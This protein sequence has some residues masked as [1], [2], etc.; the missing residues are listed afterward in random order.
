M[1][2]SVVCVPPGDGA[3]GSESVL[4]LALGARRGRLR[5][6]LNWYQRML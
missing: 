3:G 6:A 1:H 4:R 5:C 2:N